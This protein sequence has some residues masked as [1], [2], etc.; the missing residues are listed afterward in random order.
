MA[1]SRICA[2]KSK[3]PIRKL[4]VQERHQQPLVNPAAVRW[5]V[6]DLVIAELASR[7]VSG[8]D[9]S[10]VVLRTAF[11]KGNSRVAVMVRF[12]I[13]RSPVQERGHVQV[14]VIPLRWRAQDIQAD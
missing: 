11:L 3:V 8:D 9:P 7:Y 13:F 4:A 6:V 5:S 1:D 12:A 2:A 10:E 14:Q